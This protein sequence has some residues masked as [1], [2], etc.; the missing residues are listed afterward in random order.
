MALNLA[1]VAFFYIKIQL[2]IKSDIRRQEQTD[3]S[4]ILNYWLGKLWLSLL[5]SILLNLTVIYLFN[6]IC[7]LSTLNYFKLFNLT[8]RT[9]YDQHLV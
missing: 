9:K 3:D 7:A 8:L 2:R 1:F 6:F 5:L 4:H